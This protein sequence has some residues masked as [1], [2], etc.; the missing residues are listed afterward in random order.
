MSQKNRRPPQAVQ[1]IVE[2]RYAKA[3]RYWDDCG[4]LV[5]TIEAA[6]QGLVCEKLGPN[7]F[8]FVGRSSGID[9]AV[10]YWERA[11]ITQ[12]GQGDHDLAAAAAQFWNL[13]STGLGISSPPSRIGHRTWVLFHA[14]SVRDAQRRLEAKQAHWSLGAMAKG[15]GTPLAPGTT[16]RTAMEPNGR[17]LRLTVDSGTIAPKSGPG[18]HGVIVDADI[19]CELPR[20]I[21]S[22]VGEFVRSNISF[23]RDAVIP[24]FR[25]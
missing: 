23:L 6:F 4:K 1:S 2:W 5:T 9:A 18:Q 21:P 12:S 24:A 17:R 16:V 7:G 11:S 13:V 10:F 3:H 20:E 14:D 19:V 25:D 15:W 8:E 22:D